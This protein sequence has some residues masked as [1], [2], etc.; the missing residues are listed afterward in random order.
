MT[1]SLTTTD[2]PTSTGTP[3]TMT[4]SPP[5]TGPNSPTTGQTSTV[6][7]APVLSVFDYASI[8]VGLLAL[9]LTVLLVGI[10][11]MVVYRYRRRLKENAVM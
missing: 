8:G 2:M 9:S 3:S 7:E 10:M 5:T 11:S 1:T 6:T 4:I